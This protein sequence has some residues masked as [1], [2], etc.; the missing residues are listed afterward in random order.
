M[1]HWP[2]VNED[3]VRLTVRVPTQLKE[4]FKTRCKENGES[5]MV[6]P[7]IDLIMQWLSEQDRGQPTP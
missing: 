3:E 7:L 2:D 1:T 5:T 6:V 4:D